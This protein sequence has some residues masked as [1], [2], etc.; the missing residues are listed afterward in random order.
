VK[1][2]IDIHGHLG[3]IL[4]GED[5][6]YQKDKKVP[7]GKDEDF[8]YNGLKLALSRFIDP[9]GKLIGYFFNEKTAQR[10]IAAHTPRNSACTLEN[11]GEVMEENGISAMVVLP[12]HPYVTFEDVLEASK[13]DSRII[14]FTSIDYSLGK[15]AGKK[16]LEDAENGAQG[17]KIH[18]IIQR[19]SLLDEDTI[20]A[21]K[22]WEQTGKPVQPHL[23]VYYYYPTEEGHL[24]SPEYG[25]YEDFKELF[26]MFPDIKFIAA[27]SAGFEWKRL[28]EDGKDLENLYLDLSFVSRVQLKTYLKKWPVERLLY[29]SDW[30]WGYPD[31]TLKV[32]DLSVQDP[33]AK[34][35]ILYKNAK[36]LLGIS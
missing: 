6:I 26:S 14:P 36:R 22:Y 9:N 31:I 27:H 10:A 1:K 15:D 30:P 29:G 11:M 35:M 4:R 8:Y 17:L 2:I 19:K 20:E 16:L 32:I 24:Q 21:L 7:S 12:V 33:E 18:P 28:I 23:G 34:E 13:V 3:D 5:I 25:K